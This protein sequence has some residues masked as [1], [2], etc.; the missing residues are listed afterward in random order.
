MNAR[1]MVVVAGLAGAAWGQTPSTTGS[2]VTYGLT[3]T[4]CDGF[5]HP[6][7][8]P[9]GFLSP[10]EGVLVRMTASFTNQNTTASY[11]PPTPPPGSGTIR[12][13]GAGF[14]DLHITS[15]SGNGNGTW[16]VDPAAGLGVDP[17]WDLVG[18]QGWGTPANAGSD[19]LNIQF[20]QFP[21]S[22]AAIITTNPIVNIWQGAWL[23]SSYAVRPL[24]FTVAAAAASSGTPSW[25]LFK[26]S[27][28]SGIASAAAPS[29]FGSFTIPVPGPGVL[30][31]LG[32]GMAAAVRR[33]RG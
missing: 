12:G 3:W 27:G 30:G 33:R 8:N 9:N 13:L 4:E 24:T 18:P 7:P 6:V 2:T 28:G 21:T 14:V 20:G 5:G 29:V 32:V 1:A 22:P 11:T 15:T 17:T 19:L 23:P 26:I 25:V 31:V 10:G 16:I